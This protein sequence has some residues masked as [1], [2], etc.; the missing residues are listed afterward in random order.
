MEIKEIFN[1]NLH[2]KD[3]LGIHSLPRRA[4]A[5]GSAGIIYRM[6]RILL[7]YGTDNY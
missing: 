1:I 3:G 2:L 7:L 4:N 6:S 5:R